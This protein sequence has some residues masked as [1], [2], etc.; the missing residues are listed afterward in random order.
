MGI[1]CDD[2]SDAVDR[3]IKTVN[4]SCP[5]CGSS[6]W[7]IEVST[8]GYWVECERCQATGPMADNEDLAEIAWK[9]RK[10]F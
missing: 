2:M 5:F 10:K 6:K 7:G 3:D 4:S 1:W 9:Q 8:L